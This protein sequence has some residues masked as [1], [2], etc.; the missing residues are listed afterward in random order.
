MGLLESSWSKKLQ[1]DKE[2][3]DSKEWASKDEDVEFLKK[4]L[5]KQIEENRQKDIQIEQLQ[6]EKMA[7]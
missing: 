3:D 1:V 5:S 2:I 7:T 4:Q 6:N